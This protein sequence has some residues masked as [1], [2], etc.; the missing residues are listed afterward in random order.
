MANR[1][2]VPLGPDDHILGS[3]DAN[4]E[5][6]E[7][8]DFECPHCG[9]AYPIVKQVQL[10]FADDLLFAFRHFPL[11]AVHPHAEMAAETAEWAGTHD[12]FWEMH[13]LIFQ[14]QEELSLPMLLAAAD[15]LKLDQQG[16][17]VALENATF[18]PRVRRDIQSGLADGVQGTPTFFIN[19]EQHV[20]SYELVDLVD[21]I[22]RKRQRVEAIESK[23]QRRVRRAS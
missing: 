14:N 21:A 15:V 22:E 13:D 19:G 23:K 5:L 12:R 9:L 1:L 16:L 20:G 18:E 7:Y 6:V 17:A 10:H 3:S 8:G 4:V 2:S 11:I